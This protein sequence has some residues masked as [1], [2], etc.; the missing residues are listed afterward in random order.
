MEPASGIT[1]RMVE[2]LSRAGNLVVL[3]GAGVSQESGVPTF[4]GEHGL[5]RKYRAE[6]LATRKAFEADPQLVWDW[7]D[8]RRQ[9]VAEAEPNRAHEAIAVLEGKFP[10]FRLITQT[11]TACTLGPAVR[12]PLS[13]TGASGERDARASV[14]W[15]TSWK[16]RCPRYR[17]AAPAAGRS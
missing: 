1:R 8:Y 15:P 6:Q 5:W 11:R 4:R 16:A 12:F 9:L 7:Y 3:T 10:S 17:L 2:R 13:S 14:R